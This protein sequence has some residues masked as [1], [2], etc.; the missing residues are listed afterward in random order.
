MTNIKDKKIS[1]SVF[2][3]VLLCLMALPFIF[4]QHYIYHVGIISVM[5]LLLVLGLFLM[6]GL[7]G[8]MNLAQASFWALGAYGYSITAR[9][10]MPFWLSVA[11]VVLIAFLTTVILGFPTMKVSGIYFSMVTLGFG[12]ITRIIIQ[13]WQSITGGGMGIREIP[14]MR[15]FAFPLTTL[16]QIYLFI[17]GVGLTCIVLV[18]LLL[19]SNLGLALKASGSNG[20]VSEAIGINTF[21]IKVL[22]VFLNSLLAGIGGIF[23][24][25]YYGMIHPDAFTSGVSFSFVQM[26]VVGGIHSF[27]GILLMTP[28]LSVAFEY[29]RAFGE[30]QVIVYAL[31]VLLFVIFCPKGVGGFLE[32]CIRGLSG[33]KDREKGVSGVQG[34]FVV[35]SGD[36][37]RTADKEQ[38]V[39]RTENLGIDFGGISA[40]S[41]VGIELKK[42]ELL[43]VVGPNG[44][45]KTTLFN[46]ISGIYRPDSGK[47]WLKE[48]DITG[49]Y[50]HSIARLGMVRT[51]QN[52]GIY[53]SLTVM[54]SV[55]VATHRRHLQF[56][57]SGRVREL[58]RPWTKNCEDA[59]R[60]LAFVGGFDG[61]EDELCINLPYGFQKHLEIARSLALDPE[62]LLLDEPAAG[63]NQIEKEEMSKMIR[64]VVDSGV[65][66]MLIEHD[67]KLVS[68]ISDRIIVLD[69][70]K[71]IANG[72]PAEVMKDPKV[73]AAYIGAASRS[74]AGAGGLQ[75]GIA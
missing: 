35:S 49:L 11:A 30:Y 43:S 25:G 1:S 59:R 71:L 6:T 65:S 41:E 26:L 44:A 69:Y 7:S 36:P 39:L 53:D 3:V 55:C 47:V 9:A 74:P 75:E 54:E 17:L 63:L 28:V 15:P 33:K 72:A 4:D 14:K 16:P 62:I 27:T 45:G 52:L 8:Q 73:I 57:F 70:G 23:Y 24:A 31:M 60:L 19:R 20:I 37:R 68:N 50:P 34:T 32:N 29:L 66:V 48:K 18:Y 46:V 40:L 22:A 12:E 56:E 21:R 64:K 42:G 2:I 5:N 61:L 10:G 67:I 13:N 38:S 51:F 58:L